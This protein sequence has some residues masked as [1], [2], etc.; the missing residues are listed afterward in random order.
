MIFSTQKAQVSYG[1][2]FFKFK[3][4]PI[5]FN[6]FELADYLVISLDNTTKDIIKYLGI[7]NWIDCINLIMSGESNTSEIIDNF[8]SYLNTN[9]LRSVW[10]SSSLSKIIP[11]LIVE[12]NNKV[13]GITAI[14][15]TAQNGYVRNT[16]FTPRDWSVYSAINLVWK[17]ID[18]NML[19]SFRI[20][21]GS[22]WAEWNINI[23]EKELGTYV[24]KK[25]LFSTATITGQGNFQ[26]NNVIKV[27]FYCKNTGDSNNI[28][29]IDNILLEGV[30]GTVDVVPISVD[31]IEGLPANIVEF[32]SYKKTFYI[33]N[34]PDI[35]TIFTDN[36][37]NINNFG[38]RFKNLVGNFKCYLHG[39]NS[40]FGIQSLW[41]SSDGINFVPFDPSKDIFYE[42]YQIPE[43]V[44]INK[45]RIIPDEEFNGDW[46]KINI[47]A[48]GIEVFN[49]YNKQLDKS[50]KDIIEIDV[51]FSIRREQDI[52]FYF[53]KKS[54][55]NN[56][57]IE[58]L[59]E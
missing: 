11:E 25:F 10:V 26:W 13:M 49:I 45:I 36:L 57:T 16:F 2:N 34:Y 18:K 7:C 17:Q 48:D 21:D 51:S 50:I 1:M 39:G 54:K 23:E 9:A 56:L 55:L 14:Y 44:N 33:K 27:E 8:E 59:G 35:Y 53:N 41:S 15:S 38:L 47:M 4:H 58:F 52:G 28:V 31:I 43:Q 19:F 12:D 37:L 46:I 22:R 24:N 3:L 20:S 40:R 6:N 5:L 29:Y 30:M 42:M 32:S